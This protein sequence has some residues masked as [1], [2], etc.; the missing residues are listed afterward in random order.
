MQLENVSEFKYFQ[1][2]FDES[3]TD[4][5]K[6][7]KKMVNGRKVPGATRPLVNGRRLELSIQGCFM[8]HCLCSYIVWVVVRQWY[9]RKRGVRIRAAQ[10]DILRNF[11]K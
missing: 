5:A 4:S 6:C 11:R 10:M 2:V 9:K 1:C 7:C 8:R 3:G